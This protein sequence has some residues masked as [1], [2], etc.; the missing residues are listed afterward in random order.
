MICVGAAI[1]SDGAATFSAGIGMIYAFKKCEVP[2]C[3][4]RRWF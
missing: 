2:S 3:N 1:S 4:D